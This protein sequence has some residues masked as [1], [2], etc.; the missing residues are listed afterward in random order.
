MPNLSL[1]L[2]AQSEMCEAVFQMPKTTQ[3]TYLILYC[4]IEQVNHRRSDVGR[5]TQSIF[6]ML[7]ELWQRNHFFG[8]FSLVTN[9]PL[10]EMHFS[11]TQPEFSH[12]QLHVFP[13][14]YCWPWPFGCLST[15]LTHLQLA[16]NPNSQISF[17]RAA[18]Q[19][20]IPQFVCVNATTSSQMQNPPLALVKISSRW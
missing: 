6:Y 10:S 17:C 13:C 2:L 19:P 11:N 15:L 1:S 9:H 8:E 12:I 4:N 7:N 14:P 20:L 5:I 3:V 16:I 18:L